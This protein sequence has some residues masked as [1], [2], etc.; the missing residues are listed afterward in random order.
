MVVAHRAL[1][2][3]A[4]H[5]DNAGKVSEP[6]AAPVTTRSDPVKIPPS[7]VFAPLEP[8]ETGLVFPFE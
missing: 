1:A 7:P 8:G 3:L 5:D 2:W 4:R 6:M